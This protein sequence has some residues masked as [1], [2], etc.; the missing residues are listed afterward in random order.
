ME[1]FLVSSQPYSMLVSQEQ[2]VKKYGKE[3][4]GYRE[5]SWQWLYRFPNGL[6][7]SVVR[8]HFKS[9]KNGAEPPANEGT[10]EISIIRWKDDMWK[11]LPDTNR[12]VREADIE[13]YLR[14]ICDIPKGDVARLAKKQ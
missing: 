7:A 14:M 13:P 11:P 9:W 3:C 8:L 6:G 12:Q 1:E 5:D 4:P 10:V 2:L